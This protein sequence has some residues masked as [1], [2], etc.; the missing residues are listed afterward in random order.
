MPTA[1][2]AFIGFDAHTM[3]L[4]VAAESM[5]VISHSGEL[6]DAAVLSSNRKW[7]AYWKAYWK[8]RDT[9]SPLPR[10]YACEVTIPAGDP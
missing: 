3:G 5:G 1:D 2:E 6:D 9:S 7:W 8:R 4:I 10:D